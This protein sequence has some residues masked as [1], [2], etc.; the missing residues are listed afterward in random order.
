V[1]NGSL[2]PTGQAND[3]GWLTSFA[4]RIF[5]T[6][7]GRALRSAGASQ[8]LGAI[9]VTHQLPGSD[10]L[11][12]EE[13]LRIRPGVDQSAL[14]ALIRA[15]P[16]NVRPLV[17]LRFAANA[18]TD[19]WRKEHN[20]WVRIADLPSDFLITDEGE[21]AMSWHVGGTQELDA[22]WSAVERI[23]SSA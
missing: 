22:L 16:S 19:V 7:R 15:L 13:R 14:D 11:S 4:C 3:G 8:R 10:G 6:P 12:D 1:S 23:P 17:I 9:Q 5:I 20:H 18:G 2:L 21:W